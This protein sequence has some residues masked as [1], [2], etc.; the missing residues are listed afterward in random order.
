[1]FTVRYELIIFVKIKYFFINSA[2]TEFR[3]G[4]FLNRCFGVETVYE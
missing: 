3:E 4:H 2:E 1:M